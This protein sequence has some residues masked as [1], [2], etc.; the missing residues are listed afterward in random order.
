MTGFKLPL[1]ILSPGRAVVIDQLADPSAGTR[2]LAQRLTRMRSFLAALVALVLLVTGFSQAAMAAAMPCAAGQH[3]V[4]TAGAA[5]AMSADATPCH[6]DGTPSGACSDVCKRLC[7]QVP[8]VPV[9][10][11]PGLLP[12]A[13]QTLTAI[14]SAFPPSVVSAPDTPPPIA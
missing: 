8:L 4:Q 11:A 1:T 10:V 5:T 7:A 6:H 3:S 9:F 12:A 13:P 14:P 2:W